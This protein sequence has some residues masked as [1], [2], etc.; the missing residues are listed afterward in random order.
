[1]RI[2]G[3]G[4]L[5]RSLARLADRHPGVTAFAA[6]V[7]RSGGATGAGFAREAALLYE[8]LRDCSRTGGRLLY[9]STSS[10]GLYGYGEDRA[11]AVEDG[12]VRPVSA[13]GRHK[14]AMEEVIRSS[15]GEHVVLRLAYPVGRGQR[16]H[17]FLPSLVRQVRGGRVCVQRGA[18]RD[19]I[20]IRDV[21]ELVDG[22]LGLGGS[23]RLVN[24]ASGWAVPVEDIVAHIEYRLG[25]RAEHEVRE[26][27]R[28]GVVST[29]LLRKLLP[30]ATGERGFGPTYYRQVIDTYLSE[31]ECAP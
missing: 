12:P 26:V 23:P 18:R 24:L 19:L 22:L 29:V 13:Y 9:F 25:T 5:A 8:T 11:P 20:G 15:G 31:Q 14:L 10:A 6:G 3:G 27:P 30:A 16:T 21:V 2:I 4:F 1:M 17:Q 28:E 7:S